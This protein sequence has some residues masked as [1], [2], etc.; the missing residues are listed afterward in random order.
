ME[1][2]LSRHK[3]SQSA[4]PRIRIKG[5]GT[6]EEEMRIWVAMT[7]PKKNRSHLSTEQ[8]VEG[9]DKRIT[10]KDLWC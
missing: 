9:P 10:E 7:Q 5:M 2:G 4:F 6:Q 1:E 8:K 3:P